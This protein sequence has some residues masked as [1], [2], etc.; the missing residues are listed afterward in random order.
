MLSYLKNI[1]LEKC[2]RCQ[3]GDLFT[4]KWYQLKNCTNLKENCDIFGQRTQLE[5]EFYHGTG[6][7][8]YALTVGFSTITFVIWVLSTGITIRDSRIFYWL[9]VNIVALILLQP[10]IMRVSRLL[11]LSWFFHND[12]RFHPNPITEKINQKV[13]N[14]Q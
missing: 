2:P 10:L 4:H 14:I 9:A 6:Y 11:W 3:L 12:D 7:V 8:S 13:K 5:P 1:L